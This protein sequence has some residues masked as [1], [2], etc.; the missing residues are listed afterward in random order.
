MASDPPSGRRPPALD[1]DRTREVAQAFGADAE[2]YDRARPRYPDVMV[3]HIVAASPGPDVL[4]VGIGTGIAARQFAAHGCRVVG[5]DPDARMAAIARRHGFEVEIARF[6]EWD[7]AGRRF[8]TVVAGQTWH[9]VDAVAGA[10]KAAAALRTDG[11]LAVF[12]NAFEPPPDLARAFTEVYR[13]VIPESPFS[14]AAAPGLGA[15]EALCDRAAEGI[16]EAGG[17]AEP[18]RWQF[19]WGHTYSTESWLDQVPTN[20]GMH[21]LPAATLAELLAGIGTAIDAAGGTFMMRYTTDVVIA[22]RTGPGDVPSN[23]T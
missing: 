23:G 14:R 15:Y 21:Q 10:A 12:W 3:E 4:D 20:G 7:P 5:V 9:W 2:R 18:D 6:E 1:D 17:F 8:D 22:V 19:E 13:R 16:R 11:R